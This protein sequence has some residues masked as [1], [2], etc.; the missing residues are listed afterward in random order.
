MKSQ[1]NWKCP[2]SSLVLER[3]ADAQNHPLLF[4]I[5]TVECA[6]PTGKNCVFGFPYTLYLL[7]DGILQ[8][9]FML[10]RFFW[11]YKDKRCKRLSIWLKG[12]DI[13]L[14]L[15]PRT[16]IFRRSKRMVLCRRWVIRHLCYE[17]SISK[18]WNCS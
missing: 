14:I 6:N 15:T 2:T 12:P 13:T 16:R 9:P 17:R 1:P 7:F 11:F 18:C 10:E 5:L 4:L 3:S 8:N